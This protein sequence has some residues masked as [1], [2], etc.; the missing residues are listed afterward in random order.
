MAEPILVKL[1]DTNFNFISNEVLPL[2]E[3]DYLRVMATEVV[4]RLKLTVL[5]SMEGAAN[6]EKLVEIWGGFTSDPDVIAAF[7]S[8]LGQAI[9]KIGDPKIQEGLNL[10]VNP[11]IESMVILTNQETADEAKLKEIWKNF[12][13]TD[14]LVYA[15]SNLDWLLR[16][17]IKDENVIKWIMK[18]INS[19]TSK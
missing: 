9:S 15:L 18:L 12:V 4:E 7:K 1:V 13:S 16:K 5:A 19:F 10:L 14:L 8:A 2:I 3:K 17:I 11:V 6:K